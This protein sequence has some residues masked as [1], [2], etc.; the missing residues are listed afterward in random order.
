M[1][2][3]CI[4]NGVSK[5]LNERKKRSSLKSTKITLYC[6]RKVK[7]ETTHDCLSGVHTNVLYLSIETTQCKKRQRRVRNLLLRV[8][9]RRH[10]GA[11]SA[12]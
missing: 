2:N 1:Q 7:R 8:K 6:E 5:A 4:N 12:C 9:A 11:L 10:A 3:H